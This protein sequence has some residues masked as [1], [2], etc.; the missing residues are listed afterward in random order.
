MAAKT[1]DANVLAS[2]VRSICREEMDRRGRDEE[3]QWRF[4]SGRRDWR[5]CS[6]KLNMPDGSLY[7]TIVCGYQMFAFLNT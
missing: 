3:F 2:G 4:R 7:S 1:C 5:D 6:R